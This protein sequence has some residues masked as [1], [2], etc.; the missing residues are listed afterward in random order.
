MKTYQ[1]KGNTS[2]LIINHRTSK[3]T[4][5]SNVILLEGNSTMKILG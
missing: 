4:L 2:L 5:V 1:Q 3:K